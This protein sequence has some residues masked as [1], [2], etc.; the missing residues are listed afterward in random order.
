MGKQA[1]Y[2]DRFFTQRLKGQR[3]E[4]TGQLQGLGGSS[5]E[6]TV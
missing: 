5:F 3:W 4:L 2:R 1:T 6:V